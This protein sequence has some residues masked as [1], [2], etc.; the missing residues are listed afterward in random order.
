VF[1]EENAGVG[2]CPVYGCE[3]FG[4]YLRIKPGAYFFLSGGK[5][6]LLDRI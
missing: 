4:Q 5:K 1:G 2:I 6:Y 3:D